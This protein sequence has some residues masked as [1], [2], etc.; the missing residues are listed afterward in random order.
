M[1]LPWLFVSVCCP[2]LPSDF[3]E[4]QYSSID[5]NPYQGPFSGKERK[6]E[7]KIWLGKSISEVIPGEGRGNLE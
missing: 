3:I 4:I 5:L 7:S 6:L 2:L 1:Q